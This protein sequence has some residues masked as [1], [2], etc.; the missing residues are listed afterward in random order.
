[1]SAQPESTSPDED[2]VEPH[3]VPDPQQEDIEV[4]GE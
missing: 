2:P 3:A 1:M 4:V